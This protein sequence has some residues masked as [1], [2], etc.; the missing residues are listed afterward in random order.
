METFRCLQKFTHT[1][2]IN[3]I[4]RHNTAEK[5]VS[6]LENKYKESEMKHVDI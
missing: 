6:K 2:L 3:I 1:W 5:R 4:I